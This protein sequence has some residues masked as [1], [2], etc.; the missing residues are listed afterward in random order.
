M[1]AQLRT[2]ALAIAKTQLGVTES[3]GRNTGPEVDAYLF[4][5]GLPPGN[6][7]CAAFVVWCYSQAAGELRILTLPI[8]RTGKVT[9]LWDTSSARY[10][11][12]APKVGDIY[13]HATDPSQLESPGHCGIVTLVTD[14]TFS[15][16]EG[17][18]N[19]DGSREG[20][21]VWQ[22]T[23]PLAYANLGFI[24]VSTEN[25]VKLRPVS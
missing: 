11:R 21:S 20:D 14:T 9:R 1:L 12:Q 24:D 7:W 25:T 18:T 22:H 17:N 6:P 19:K 2:R 3:G 4:A 15:A 10:G 5:V 8:K 13:C 23:R 16:I